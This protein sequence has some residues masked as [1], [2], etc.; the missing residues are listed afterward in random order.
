MGNRKLPILILT[1]E[2]AKE[3]VSSVVTIS[4]NNYFKNISVLHT[5]YIEMVRCIIFGLINKQN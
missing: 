3:I 5:K 2:N 1:L 4:Q